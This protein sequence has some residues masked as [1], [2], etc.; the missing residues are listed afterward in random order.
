MPFGWFSP[1]V[2][3]MCRGGVGTCFGWFAPI[4]CGVYVSWLSRDMFFGWFTPT[5]CGVYVS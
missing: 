5:V 4:F 2:G 1:I 3:F